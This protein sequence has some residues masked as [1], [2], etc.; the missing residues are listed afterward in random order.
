MKIIMMLFDE[1]KEVKNK[2]ENSNWFFAFKTK[3]LK[4]INEFKEK[5][6]KRLVSEDISERQIKKIEPI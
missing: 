2:E 6:K 4:N 5:L 3:M 1:E